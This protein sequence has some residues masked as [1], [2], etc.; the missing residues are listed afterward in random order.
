MGPLG[1]QH[2]S[3]IRP[4]S[5]MALPQRN[6]AGRCGSHLKY[7]V[8]LQGGRWWKHMGQAPYVEAPCLPRMAGGLRHSGI[9]VTGFSR[10][11]QI[12]LAEGPFD[13]K[14]NIFIPLLPA[15]VTHPITNIAKPCLTS[16]ITLPVLSIYNHED[17]TGV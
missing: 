5:A 13:F 15:A 3:T 7:T 12:S 9:G 2:S 8:P 16:L 17:N 1:G 11:S 6:P 4:L 14:N 10:C